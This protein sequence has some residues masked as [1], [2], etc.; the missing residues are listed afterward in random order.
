MSDYM[1]KIRLECLG[2]GAKPV[3]P[4]AD[5]YQLPDGTFVDAG[6]LELPDGTIVEANDLADESPADAVRDYLQG[7]PC[8]RC[9]SDQ[10]RVTLPTDVI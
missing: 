8:P 5:H 2:C 9:G 6:T 1:D 10:M 4:M 3:V 7:M